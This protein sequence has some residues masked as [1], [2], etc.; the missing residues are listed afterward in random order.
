MSTISFGVQEQSGT[1]TCAIAFGNG[2]RRPSG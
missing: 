1:F 2:L